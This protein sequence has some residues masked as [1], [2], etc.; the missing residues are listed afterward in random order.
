MVQRSVT[1]SF[2]VI[3]EASTKIMHKFPDFIGVNDRVAWQKM[4]GMRNQLAHGY[5]NID[6]DLVWHTIQ[7][8][9]TKLN[10]Q[11]EELMTVNK[12]DE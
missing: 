8:E 10:V 7:N 2:V 5:F 11:I 9:L 6:Y 1:F 12:T 3:G 4:R